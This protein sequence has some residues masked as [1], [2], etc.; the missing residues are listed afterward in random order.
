[1]KAMILAAAALLAA[2]FAGLLVFGKRT[3]S[4]APAVSADNGATASSPDELSALRREVADLKRMTVAQ[5]ARP[6]IAAS[7]APGSHHAGRPQLPAPERRKIITDAMEDRYARETPD[8]S[9]SVKRV[10]EIRAAF[11]G[12]MPDV[13]VRSVECQSTICKIELEHQDIQSQESLMERTNEVEGLNEETFFDCN[14]AT[15]PPRTV[16]YMGREGHQL[17]RPTF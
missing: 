4:A 14:T 17:P 3:H 7:S 9:W 10:H 15:T 8:P 6:L 2:S 11:T 13:K 1:M 12:G 16:M 5:A